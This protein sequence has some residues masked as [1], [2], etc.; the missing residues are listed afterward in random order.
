MFHC[1]KRVF[2]PTYNK[3]IMEMVEIHNIEDYNNLPMTKWNIRQPN[4]DENRENAINVGLDLILMPG[5]AFD[6][7][8]C[9]RCGHG[10]GYYDKYLTRLFEKYPRNSIKLFG[11]AFE[12]QLVDTL[13]L[14]DHD[15]PLDSIISP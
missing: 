11:L 2:V 13:P 8:N 9:G 14:E 12:E 3:N 4:L 10:M 5:V 7:Q 15:V 1:N 6:K